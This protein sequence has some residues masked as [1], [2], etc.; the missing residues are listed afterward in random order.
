MHELR[1]LNGRRK[2][3][4]G[5]VGIPFLKPLRCYTMNSALQSMY[6]FGEGTMGPGDPTNNIY[7]MDPTKPRWKTVDGF[8]IV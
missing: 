3:L 1:L 4:I 2:K 5:S 6:Y 7:L 8:D